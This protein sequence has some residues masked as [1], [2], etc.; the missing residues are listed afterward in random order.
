[1]P[2][3]YNYKILMIQYI[4]VNISITIYMAIFFFAVYSSYRVLLRGI[5]NYRAPILFQILSKR[6]MLQ[7]NEGREYI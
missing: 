7:R 2:E 4:T 6:V 3:Y 1:M 5:I